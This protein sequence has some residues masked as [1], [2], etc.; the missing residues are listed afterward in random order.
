MNLVLN[1]K[2]CHFMVKEGNMVGYKVSIQGIK[3][4]GAKIETIDKLP[5]PTLV[6]DIRSFL[7]HSRFNKIFI[8]DF[9]KITKSLCMLFEK[10][11]P[12]EFDEKNVAIFQ[13]LQI[14]LII[15]PIIV[16][17]NWNLFLR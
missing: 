15:A 13:T 11:V 7:G 8:K 6:K 3:V 5:P 14:S 1:Q 9:L 16:A 2:K 17:P 10:D 12:F 4:H